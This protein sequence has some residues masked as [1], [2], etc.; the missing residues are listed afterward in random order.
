MASGTLYITLV[1]ATLD[2]NTE[3]WGKMDPYV[4][5]KSNG[6]E[7]RTKTHEDGHKTPKWN[8]ELTLDVT[9]QFDELKITVLEE[10]TMS[11]DLVGDVS[12]RIEQVCK[13]PTD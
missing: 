1:E 4:T 7:K 8:E 5:I 12:F 3:Y 6:Q 2:R 11:S 13:D 10:D 9:D